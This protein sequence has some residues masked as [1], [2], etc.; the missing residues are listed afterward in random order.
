MDEK[1]SILKTL[2]HL[3]NVDGKMVEREYSFLWAIANQLGI[4]NKVEFDKILKHDIEFQP[5][6]NEFERIVQFQRMILMMSVDEHTSE[7]EL[8]Y[9]RQ[10]GV[11]LG[12]NP[13]AIS[14]VLKE[15]KNHPNNM[16]PPEVLIDIFKSHHN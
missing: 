7:S 5:P 11:K 12:L 1:M 4:N 14:T 2:I 15:M 9:V 13:I 16:I 8:N 6:E 10:M 3:A